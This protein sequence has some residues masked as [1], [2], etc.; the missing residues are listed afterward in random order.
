[1]V[2]E[3]LIFSSK[4]LQYIAVFVNMLVCRQY[5]FV[6]IQYSNLWMFIFAYIRNIQKYSDKRG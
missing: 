1:M 2:K 5:Y 6:Y 4:G 3:S